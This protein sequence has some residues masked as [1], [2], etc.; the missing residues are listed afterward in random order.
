MAK[1]YENGGE[2]IIHQSLKVNSISLSIQFS[3]LE[4]PH[5]Q[6]R[7]V[8]DPDPRVAANFLFGLR[9]QQSLSE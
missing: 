4:N 2:K 6:N 1:F 3:S 8:S 7:T 5:C 9:S